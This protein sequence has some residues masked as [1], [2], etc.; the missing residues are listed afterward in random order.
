MYH[1]TNES[2]N[3]IFEYKERVD[4]N[5]NDSVNFLV[6]VKV[7]V[8]D[9]V[10]WDSLGNI[11][12]PPDKHP[13]GQMPIDDSTTCRTWVLRAV[14]MLDD[15]GYIKLKHEKLK[16]LEDECRFFAEQNLLESERSV[17]KS[18]FSTA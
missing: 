15:F 1:A 2:G 14:G 10:L 17:M 16:S 6:A 7:A 8:M 5:I 11:L 4:S 3:K 12:S 18:R 13:D 9:S